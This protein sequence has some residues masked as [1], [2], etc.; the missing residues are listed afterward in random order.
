MNTAE[1]G[2]PG[3]QGT[4]GD[5]GG[6]WHR[7][8]TM[9]EGWR[10]FLGHDPDPPVLLPAAARKQLPEQDRLAYDE[11][12]MEYHVR[13]GV[14]QTPMLAEVLQAAGCSRC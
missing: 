10:A 5:D 4:P 12:R 11:W 8:L 14:I 7:H 9:L 1:A 13:L 3:G 2:I 6:G